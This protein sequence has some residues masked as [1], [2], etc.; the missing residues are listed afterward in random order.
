MFT[1]VFIPYRGYYTS[2]YSRYGKTYKNENAIE[3]SASTTKAWLS[4]KSIDPGV[5]D[6]VLYGNSVH[7]HHGFWSGPWSTA[8]IG[9]SHTTGSMLSQ[10]CTTGA[11]S[12]YQA[13]A[14]IQLG[15]CETTYSLTSDR[16]SNG[17]IISWPEYDTT[18]DWVEDNFAFDPW[19]QTSMLETAERV[20][21]LK[22]IS[23]QQLDE[24]TVC[25]YEQ[26]YSVAKKPYMFGVHGLTDDE[27]VKRMDMKRL[28]RLKP[29]Q[30][31][32]Y[33]SL[34]NL[35]YPADGH[36]G[37]F[38][39]TKKKADEITADREITIKVISYGYSRCEKSL[40]PIAS[41]DATRMALKHAD[42]NITDMTVINQHNAFAVNDVAFAQEFNI[43]PFKMNGYG[44]PLVYGHPQSPVL[45]RLI[46]EGIEET[47]ARG[48]GYL[49]VTGAAG[50]DTGAAVVLKID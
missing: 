47:V 30:E 35:T 22:N 11:T 34:G 23:R 9:A 26:Y 16:T 3:L 5:I 1:D 6:F 29:V 7:Q 33:H 25:R 36:C 32:G 42:L 48:G 8:M 4:S 12:L 28:S 17:P 15:L 50:G 31:N 14:N 21:K 39:T 41:V 44:S 45:S 10:A 40:M 38:V 20:A 2:P 43:D 13:S 46:I 24:V 49:L 27:G 19:G 37:I 18:E